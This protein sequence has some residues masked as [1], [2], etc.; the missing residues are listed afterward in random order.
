MKMVEIGYRSKVKEFEKLNARL[1]RAEK[2]LEKKLAV[3]VKLGVS[4][5]TND[6]HREWLEGVETTENG[7]IINKSDI[8]KNGAWFDLSLARDEV[9][10]VREEI[11][12]AE[13]RL[14][15]A[16][17]KLEAYH[18]EVRALDDLKAKEDLMRKEFEAEQKEWA[19]DGITLERR[20]SGI[21]P[22]GKHFSIER[23]SG[24]TDRSRHCYTL[25][26][27]G[28][29]VVFTSGEFWRAYSVV[30]YN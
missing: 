9:K 1:Q 8:K 18:A 12:R 23:N 7:W 5:W 17:D 13:K 21:T 2:A 20:Y 10:V 22:Q 27:E 3:A 24:W 19:K 30:K 14:E 4:E 11:E 29:G 16:E 15:R 28:V 6:E 26:L 25:Y